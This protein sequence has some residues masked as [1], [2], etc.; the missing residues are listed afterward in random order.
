MQSIATVDYV[1]NNV[2]TYRGYT[3]NK[4]HF[5]TA[6]ALKNSNNRA[7]LHEYM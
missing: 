3:V 5:R 6:N 2:V 1:L 4:K 7:T